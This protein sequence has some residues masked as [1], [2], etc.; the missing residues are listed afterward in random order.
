MVYFIEK[1]E[2]TVFK[3]SQCTESFCSTTEIVKLNFQMDEAKK[4]VADKLDMIFDEK[5]KSVDGKTLK[6]MSEDLAAECN[7]LEPDSD[8]YV[9]I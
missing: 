4:L 9:T 8:A 1:V 2:N 5:V 3:I 6:E 7:T